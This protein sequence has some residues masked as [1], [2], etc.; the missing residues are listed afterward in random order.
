[1]LFAVFGGVYLNKDRIPDYCQ[2]VADISYFNHA[3]ELLIVNEFYHQSPLPDGMFE[4]VVPRLNMSVPTDGYG[5]LAEFSF[6]PTLQSK[7]EIARH[8]HSQN[9]LDALWVFLFSGVVLSLTYAL[10]W[11][12]ESDAKHAFD[13]NLAKALAWALRLRKSEG[14]GRGPLDDLAGHD[15]GRPRT[16]SGL[17]EPLLRRAEVIMIDS[18]SSN[19]SWDRITVASKSILSADPG[20]SILADV[21]GSIGRGSVCALMGPSGA[22]KTTLLNVLAGRAVGMLS[23]IHI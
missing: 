19:F 23:L 11:F 15:G 22:G 20:Q 5:I 2:W 4:F 10:L 21:S 14:A 13:Q 6:L 3:Y 1:M 9:L 18:A 17:N 8:V 16:G 12:L 7:G